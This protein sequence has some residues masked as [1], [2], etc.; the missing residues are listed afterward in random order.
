MCS[1]IISIEVFWYFF[2]YWSFSNIDSLGLSI[3]FLSTWRP[4]LKA[5]QTSGL[6][7]GIVVDLED[8][9]ISSFLTIINLYSPYSD[10]VSFPWMGCHVD[11]M[12]SLILKDLVSSLALVSR[13]EGS[14]QGASKKA[15]CLPRAS[16]M[17]PSV[18]H[19]WLMTMGMGGMCKV[20]SAPMAPLHFLRVCYSTSQLVQFLHF[21]F[22]LVILL[23]L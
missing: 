12:Q 4:R 15:R 16:L 19:G 22:S 18:C 23:A 1:G 9:N 5:S 2:K 14:I 7:Y 3:G 20:T 17:E 11:S 13:M 6:L 8:Q 10:R 21:G